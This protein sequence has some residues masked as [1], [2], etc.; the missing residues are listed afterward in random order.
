MA[1]A[2]D[3]INSLQAATRIAVDLPSG[4][5][6]DTGQPIGGVAVRATHTLALLTLKPGLFTGAGRDHAGDIWLDTLGCD[7]AERCRQRNAAGQCR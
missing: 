1:R 3:D 7:D 5:N 2:I 4:L 6:A